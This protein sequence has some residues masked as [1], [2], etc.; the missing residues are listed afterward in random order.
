[1]NWFRNRSH[2][3]NAINKGGHMAGQRC[4]NNKKY[5][6]YCGKHKNMNSVYSYPLFSVNQPQIV[7]TYVEEK[8]EEVEV[9]DRKNCQM[10]FSEINEH[11]SSVNLSCS[12]SFHLRCFFII[13]SNELGFVNPNETCPTCKHNTESEMEKD[14]SICL[15]ACLENIKKLPCG[16]IFH[17]NCIKD[18]DWRNDGCPNCRQ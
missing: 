3:C 4:R 11:I 6:D 17:K 15:D 9:E 8:K 5:G 16:H 13:N 10:C 12:H 7:N 2:E 1:M 14:C 18:W